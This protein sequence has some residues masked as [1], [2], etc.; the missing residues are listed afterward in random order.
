[1]GRTLAP[2]ASRPYRNCVCGADSFEFRSASDG[3][4]M[5]RRL[6]LL[7]LIAI[8]CTPLDDRTVAAQT[9]EELFDDHVIQDVRLFIN[10]HDLQ[11]LRDRYKEDI[12]VPADFEWRGRRVRNVAVRSRGLATRSPV[13]LGLKVDFNRYAAGQ[14]FLGHTALVL[15]ILLQDPSLVRERLSMTL[16][17]RLGEPASRESFARVYINNSYEGI[18]AIVE[19]VDG[20]FLT[21]TRGNKSGYLF[22]RH[23][24]QPYYGEDLGEDPAAYRTVFEPRTH[25]L[26]DDT[27]LYSPFRALFYEVNQ[28]VDTVWRE[29]VSRYVD[30]QQF[31]THV[32]IETFL[33]EADGVLGFAGMANF[34]L[35]RGPVHDQHR[36]IV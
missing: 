32:A 16:F 26:Q 34:Y 29:R 27:V 25:E 13:K 7:A 33:S 6:I 21:R 14:S 23:F 20:E 8:A 9:V 1:S 11:E 36:L 24:L 19:P 4:M 28:L 35:F 17:E 31:V 12:Y 2:R 5:R 15:D 30:L 3:L 18:F 10:E 22:E